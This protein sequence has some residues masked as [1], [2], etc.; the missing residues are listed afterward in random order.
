LPLRYED[1]DDLALAY[2]L[3]SQ[4][5]VFRGRIGTENWHLLKYFFNS[6]AQAAA[7]SPESYKPFD[8]ISPP[9]RIIT[10]FWTR[11][12]RTMLATICS[13]IGLQCHVSWETAKQDFVPFVKIMLQKDKANPISTWLKLAPEEAEYI[14]NMKKF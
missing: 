4:A 7:I 6:L 1:P 14:I 11:G 9:I 5:D 13:K 10:L 2:D 12:K 3:V 8:F